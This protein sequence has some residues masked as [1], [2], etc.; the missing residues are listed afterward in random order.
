MAGCS[1]HV[2]GAHCLCPGILGNT[3]GNAAAVGTRTAERKKL[4][5]MFLVE[6]ALGKA[7]EIA[8]DDHTLTKPP[9]GARS[10]L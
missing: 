4:G 7:H 5:V 2:G 6:A 9:K 10:L 1:G 8:T 3:L